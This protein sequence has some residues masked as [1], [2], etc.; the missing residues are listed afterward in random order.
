MAEVAFVVL[1]EW[2]QKGMGTLLLEYITQVALKRGV[3]GFYAKVLPMNK[4]MLAVF[5]NSGYNVSTEFDG[6]IYNVNYAFE[7][8]SK[9]S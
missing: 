8:I 4:P 9:E 7:A 6:E 3:K 1:D 2:Q 5:Q